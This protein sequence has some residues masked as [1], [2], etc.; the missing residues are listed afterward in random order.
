MVTTLNHSTKGSFPCVT[1]L[2][3]ITVVPEPGTQNTGEVESVNETPG[4]LRKQSMLKSRT[5]SVPLALRA[6]LKA[7][8]SS[9]LGEGAYKTKIMSSF[10]CL[11]RRLSIHATWLRPSCEG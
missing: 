7:T 3:R 1:R 10:S 6:Y 4:G 11:L 9:S 8:P 5:K 2:L